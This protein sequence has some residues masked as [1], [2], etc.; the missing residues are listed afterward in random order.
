M[1]EKIRKI[2]IFHKKAVPLHS[3]LIERQMPK[4]HGKTN[5]RTLLVQVKKRDVAQPGSA[6]VWGTGGRK[7]KSCHPDKEQ[8]NHLIY[9]W[10][11]C[12]CSIDCSANI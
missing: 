9:R 4:P 1:Q 5:E 10:L 3:F 12:F 6:T 7:F 11:F 2:C 8:N